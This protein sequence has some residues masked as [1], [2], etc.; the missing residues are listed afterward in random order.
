MEGG[1]NQNYVTKHD[2]N[3][4]GT[5]DRYIIVELEIV[6]YHRYLRVLRSGGSLY[7]PHK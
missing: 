5:V 1:Q 6:P 3:Y 7:N 2:G 4:T